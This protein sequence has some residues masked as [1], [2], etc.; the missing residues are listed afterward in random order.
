MKMLFVLVTR[1]DDRQRDWISETAHCI[2]SQQ[3]CMYQYL[4]C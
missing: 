4:S 1:Y 2:S 3:P